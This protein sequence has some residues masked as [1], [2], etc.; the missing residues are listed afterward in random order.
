MQAI[1]QIVRIPRSHEVKIKIPRHIAED[2]LM[3][4]ILLVKERNR[5]FTDKIEEL[6]Q[7]AKDPL[8]LK[9]MEEVSRDFSDADFEGWE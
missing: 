1:R 8:F 5:S 9:D 7:A 3:E 6:K 4:V 2:E